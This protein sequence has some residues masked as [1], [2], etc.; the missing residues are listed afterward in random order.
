MLEILV[1]VQ[2][3]EEQWRRNMQ[4]AMFRKHSAHLSK[5][6]VHG[7]SVFGIETGL[8]AQTWLQ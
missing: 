1:Q 2:L 5:H 7:E 6:R 4:G 8:K 3:G